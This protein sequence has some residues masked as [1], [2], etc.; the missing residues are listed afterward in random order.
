V[1]AYLRQR[2]CFSGILDCTNAAPI[3]TFNLLMGNGGQL[4]EIPDLGLLLAVERQGDVLTIFDAAARGPVRFVDLV[5]AL[6][7]P[8]VRTVR[9]GFN[10]DWLVDPYRLEDYPDT[11]HLFARGSFNPPEAFIFP[12]LLRT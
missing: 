2:C 4:Y 10:P 12:L 1:Q 9:F 3:Q 11:A 8:G 7:F 6:A 5:P